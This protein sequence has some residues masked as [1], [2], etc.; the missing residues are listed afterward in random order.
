MVDSNQ[1]PAASCGEVKAAKKKSGIG[2]AGP[3]KHCGQDKQLLSNSKGSK[4]YACGNPKCGGRV[5]AGNTIEMPKRGSQGQGES[6]GGGR[7]RQPAP[8]PAAQETEK[9]DFF[10]WS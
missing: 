1:L 10:D 5:V 6:S 3:C 8:A 7:G 9:K 4:Y 2:S